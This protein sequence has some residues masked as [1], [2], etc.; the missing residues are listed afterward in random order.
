MKIFLSLIENV[1]ERRSQYV[2]DNRSR[3]NYLKSSCFAS[4]EF[5][6][7][8]VKYSF[9]VKKNKTLVRRSNTFISL[10]KTTYK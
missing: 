10:Q 3:L 8:T 4:I 1:K 5:D 9:I 6:C 7:L 2:F